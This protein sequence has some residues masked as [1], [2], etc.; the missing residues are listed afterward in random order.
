MEN[1]ERLE[2]QELQKIRFEKFKGKT[3]TFE[4]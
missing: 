2:E 1:V 4:I 3:R